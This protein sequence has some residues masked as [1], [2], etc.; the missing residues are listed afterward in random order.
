MWRENGNALEGINPLPL[1][2]GTESVSINRKSVY[3]EGT[4]CSVTGKGLTQRVSKNLAS[5]IP[6]ER[7]LSVLKPSPGQTETLSLYH[8]KPGK[9][10][11]PETAGQETSIEGTV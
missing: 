1:S 9:A 6:W 11:S 7:E 2:L 8:G 10:A 3:L 4:I 5:L